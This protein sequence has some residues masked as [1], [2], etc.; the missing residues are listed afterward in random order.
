M[1]Q[2]HSILL[3]TSNKGK[4]RELGAIFKPLDIN[5]LT[6]ADLKDQYPPP[7]ETGPDFLTNAILKARYYSEKSQLPALA[8][9]SGLEV[10]ALNGEPGVYSARYGGENLSD[11]ERNSYLLQKMAKATDRRAR[12]K[13]V[14]ALAFKDQ[15]LTWRGELYGEIAY[16][17]LGEEGFG[18][19][20]IF[21][22]PKSGL[23]LAQMPLEAK[24]LISHR[25][26]A[27]K[28][29]SEDGLKIEAFLCRFR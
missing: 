13:S 28:A 21:I 11:P 25:A 8:D 26:R 14:L 10:K 7:E 17:P 16:E 1:R 5:V 15:S 6:L 27:A 29:L 3:A 4:I 12:F 20:P 22:E 19:D 9:D 24:N 23:T 2:N 18:Y